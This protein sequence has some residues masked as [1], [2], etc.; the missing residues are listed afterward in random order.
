MARATKRYVP[1]RGDI[2]MCDFNPVAGHEQAHHRPALVLS[3]QVFNKTTGLAVLA[4]ITSTV[5]G[6]GLEVQINSPGTQGVALIQ[7]IR[8]VDFEARKA[9]FR[10]RA[11]PSAITEA[12]R[13]AA[14]L[15]K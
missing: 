12:C 14:L 11:E 7:Q 13:K 4:P 15:F 3:P 8:S 10:E 1:E 9:S 2:V 5:R 6:H